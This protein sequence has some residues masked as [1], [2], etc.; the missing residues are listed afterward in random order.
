MLI[1]IFGACCL[2]KLIEGAAI[3]L[4]FLIAEYIERKIL[5]YVSNKLRKILPATSN[6][7]NILNGG[8]VDIQTVEIGSSVCVYAGETINI[9]GIVEKGKASVDESSITGESLPTELIIGSEAKSG[10]LILNGFIQIRTTKKSDHSL[11]SQ[12][13]EMIDEA[14]ATKSK[15][16]KFVN[17][18]AK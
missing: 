9:D 10:T 13:K 8:Q 12:I 15:M 11:L 6:T 4:I 5:C 2:N 14:Q 1:A 3:S 18:F 17:K 7:V 16:E